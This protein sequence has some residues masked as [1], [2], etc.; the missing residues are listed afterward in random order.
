[1]TNL[2]Y[3][4]NVTTGL[5]EDYI[6]VMEAAEERGSL[7]NRWGEPRRRNITSSNYLEE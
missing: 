1:M 4:G 5:P 2:I 3:Q 7:S 6:S